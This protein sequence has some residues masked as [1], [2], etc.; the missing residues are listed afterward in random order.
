MLVGSQVDDVGY[1]AAAICFVW[2]VVGLL[3]NFGG[4][5][6]LE[7]IMSPLTYADK[8]II[9]FGTTFLFLLAA[10][11]SLKISTTFSRL[12]VSCFAATRL[13]YN[14]VP[15]H[16]CRTR[17][18]SPRRQARVHPQRRHSGRRRAG[19]TAFHL[20]R[21][22]QPAFHHGLGSVSGTRIVSLVDVRIRYWT[23]S[24][25]SHRTFAPTKLMTSLLRCH[26][27]QTR[28]SSE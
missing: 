12:W 9:A 2:V 14:A 4:L 13:R 27:P 6:R 1:Y 3:M 20:H 8:I 5:Y 26:G 21:K 7:P 15:P 10:A 19:P 22:M 23:V 18:R 28:R 24:I 17:Y 25:T 16:S 11:F